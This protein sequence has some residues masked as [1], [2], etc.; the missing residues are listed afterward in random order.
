MQIGRYIHLSKYP[1][2]ILFLIAM[3]ALVACNP[4]A[5]VKILGSASCNA[6]FELPEGVS[7]VELKN[8]KI[9]FYNVSTGEVKEFSS[10]DEVTINTG[11]Y[12]VD[13]QAECD[14]MLHGVKQRGRLVSQ[15]TEFLILPRTQSEVVTLPFHLHIVPQ[16]E[17]FVMDEIFFTG[18][19]HPSG[20]QYHGDNYVILYNGTDH[21]LYADGIAF[22]ESRFTN[23]IRWDYT[24]DIRHEAFAAQAVYV[25]P[26]SG[27]EHPVEPGG[28]F[29]IGDTGI[30]HRTNNPNSFDL[31][32][33]D[34]EWYDVSTVPAHQDFDSPL[35]PNLDKWYCYTKSFFVLHNRGFRSYVL[36]RTPQGLDKETFLKDYLYEYTYVLTHAGIDYPMT[37]KGYKIPN[38]WVIDG[39]NLCVQAKFLWNILPEDI[40]AG[41]TNCGTMDHQKDRYFHSVRRKYLGKDVNGNKIVQDTNNSTEDF[42]PMVMPSIIEDQG[43]SIDAK[44]TPCTQKTYDGVLPIE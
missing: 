15:L 24:P 40:D 13:Y 14:Y 33:I 25:I 26:G 5:E 27:K 16:V 3:L 23:V 30:D 7:D 36:A 8:V 19:L 6:S 1:K 21:T 22:C 2:G 39:V 4:E 44:G 42:N 43:T 31:S 35:V 28:R 10:L 32:K 9:R 34:Y 41:W 12:N 38:K 18:T 29:I 11:L 37:G 20:K 17:D